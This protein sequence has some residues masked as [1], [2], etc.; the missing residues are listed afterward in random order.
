MDDFNNTFH[1]NI[2]SSDTETATFSIT[3]PFPT[4]EELGFSNPG[5]Y[6]IQW[7]RAYDGTGNYYYPGQAQAVGS[8]SSH[9]YAIWGDTETTYTTTESE[10]SSIADAIRLKGGTSSALAYPSGFISAINAI[11]GGDNTAEDSI[12]TRTISGVYENS[13]V[14][15]VGTYAFAFC[16]SLTTASFPNVTT[17]SSYAFSNCTSLTTA[18][19]QKAT[20]T[21]SYAFANCT[22]LNTVSFPNATTIATAAFQSCIQL[23]AASFPKAIIINSYAFSMCISL[24]TVSFPSV[25][26]IYSYAF[27]SCRSLTTASFPAATKIGNYAFRSCYNLI[28]LYL[29]GSSVVTLSGSAAFNSTPIGGYSTSAGRYGS[30]YVPTSLLTSYK[31]ANYWSTISSRIVGY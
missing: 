26:T 16:S 29:S 15:K 3:N 21:G 8:L 4:P 25:T 22:S 24:N 14:D 12:I 5:H 1:R 10:I 2:N 13:R 23:T 19:F 11:S 31:A 28:S 6:F 30:V 7:N 20:T 18:N 9:Y 27:Q 17:I